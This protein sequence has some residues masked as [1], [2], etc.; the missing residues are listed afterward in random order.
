MRVL[1]AS[2]IGTYLYC[3]RAWW[4]QKNGV[5]S[6]RLPEMALGTEKHQI[7]GRRVAASDLIRDV[8]ILLFITGM[9]SLIIY[10]VQHYS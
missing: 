5:P 9:I 1:R 6:S 7:H 10:F 8:A 2:E 3:A 4:Y